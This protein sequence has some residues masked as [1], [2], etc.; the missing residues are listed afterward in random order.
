MR[1]SLLAGDVGESSFRH[2]SQVPCD[3]FS[4]TTNNSGVQTKSSPAIELGPDAL[5]LD[6]ELGSGASQKIVTHPSQGHNLPLKNP[7]TF[8]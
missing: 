6:L 8:M 3:S 2:P 7:R 5:I 1:G 4:S